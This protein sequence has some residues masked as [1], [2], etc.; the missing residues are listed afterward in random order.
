MGIVL[1]SLPR[2]LIARSALLKY[3]KPSS[4]ILLP[5][6]TNFKNY[7]GFFSP[8]AHMHS[9]SARSTVNIT[10]EKYHERQFLKMFCGLAHI[11]DKSEGNY[12]AI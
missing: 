7:I 3:L 6:K 11:G 10:T 9:L 4:S 8:V 5:G 12:T 2:E 1:C